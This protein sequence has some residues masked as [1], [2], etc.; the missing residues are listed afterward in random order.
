MNFLGGDCHWGFPGGAVVKKPPAK[1]G[2]TRDVGSIPWV[3]KIPRRWKWQP[4]PV[5]LPGKF[6]GQWGLAGYSPRGLKVGY[7]LVTK[8]SPN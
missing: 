8:A 2:D 5:L 3:R 4:T 6:H 1:A 7:N